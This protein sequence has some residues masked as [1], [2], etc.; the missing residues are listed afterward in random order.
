MDNINELFNLNN[1][2]PTFIKYIIYYLK[3]V[4][5]ILTINE[6][7]CIL[8][9]KKV[10]NTL[11][12]NTITKII[13]KTAKSVVLSQYL[14]SLDKMKI[15]LYNSGIYIYTGKLL[16]KY[17]IYHYIDYICKIKKEET[18]TKE[19]FILTNKPNE[20]DENIITYFAEHFKRIN[21][22]TKNITRFKRLESILNE[23][24]GIAITITNNKRKSLLKA[25]IIVNLDFD[26]DCLNSY[27]INSN[28]IIIQTDS[29]IKIKS[30]LFTGTNVVD[31]QI[32]YSCETNGFTNK[33]FEKFDSKLLYESIIINK[34]Y[35]SIIEKMKEDN[36]KIVNLI[37]INGI[38]NNKE[39]M[40][41]IQ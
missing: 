23:K 19:I 12:I 13:L 33:A 34:N 31:S 40:K 3:K 30:K 35:K 39:F 21:I 1:K 18:Y 2:L 20:L 4:F 5:C 9:Y 15:N 28:A 26:E 14:N 37:G 41:N 6:K 10:K 36:L 38:I 7:V 24:M 11:I 25:K 32:I 22:V 27:T 16:K 17:L 29:N 8:P